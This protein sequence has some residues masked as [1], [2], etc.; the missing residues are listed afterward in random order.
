MLRLMERDR[1]ELNRQ[2]CRCNEAP[3]RSRLRLL[4]LVLLPVLLGGGQA[5]CTFMSGDADDEEEDEEEAA[6]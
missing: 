2:P 1:N 4:A 6:Q 3:E 5:Q